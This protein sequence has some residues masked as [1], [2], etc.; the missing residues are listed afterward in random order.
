MKPTMVTPVLDEDSTNEAGAMT[1]N[2]Q[3]SHQVSLAALG[4]KKKRARGSTWKPPK[5]PALEDTSS[6]NNTDATAKTKTSAYGQKKSGLP[7]RP[8]SR[9]ISQMVTSSLPG[10]S[11]ELPAGWQDDIEG[12]QLLI[13]PIACRSFL[14]CQNPNSSQR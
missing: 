10:A 5:A 1:P 8:L 6:P 12:N 9:S 13:F 14:F 3:Q 4:G 2:V 11:L 7:P